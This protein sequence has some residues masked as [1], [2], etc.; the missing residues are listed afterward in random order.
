MTR[1][2]AYH[3]IRSLTDPPADLLAPPPAGTSSS[4]S[5]PYEA[6]KASTRGAIAAST[7]FSSGLRRVARAERGVQA[8]QEYNVAEC[9]RRED[10]YKC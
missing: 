5:P 2:A 9:E 4:L 6:L 8:E 10:I 1:L 3:D 7:P